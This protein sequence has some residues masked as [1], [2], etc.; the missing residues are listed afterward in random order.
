MDK[1]MKKE[2]KINLSKCKIGQR[3]RRRNGDVVE[4]NLIEKPARDQW[5]ICCG[6]VWCESNGRCNLERDYDIVAILPLPKKKAPKG[7]KMVD[8][9]QDMIKEAI[10]NAEMILKLLKP[11]LK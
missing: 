11:L 5:P 1:A 4:I 6:G 7:E 2:P 8:V 3:V 10:S 9:S